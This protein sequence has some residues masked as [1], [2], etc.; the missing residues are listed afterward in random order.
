VAGP[1][2][3]HP[4]KPT[5]RRRSEQDA[6]KIRLIIGIADWYPKINKKRLSQKKYF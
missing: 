4:A 6:R 1:I 5:A 2:S 3:R